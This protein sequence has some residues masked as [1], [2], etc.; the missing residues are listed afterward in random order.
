MAMLRR[1]S[2]PLISGA[3]LRAYTPLATPMKFHM[4]NSFF[5]G[6]RGPF[7]SGKS[8]S[9][10]MELLS[11]AME[12]KPYEGT[13]Y[14]RCACI[15]NSYP[16]L[17]STT[18]KTWTAWLPVSIC[19]V[20]ESIPITAYMNVALGDGTR[21]DFEAF[22]LS[23]DHPDDVRKLK[24]LE[25]TMLWMNEASE[26]GSEVLE[27]ASARVGRFPDKQIGGPSFSGIIADTNSPDDTHW[28]YKLAEVEKPKGYEFFTQPPAMIEVAPKESSGSV[29]VDSL[30]P[31]YVLNDGTKGLPPAENT[32]NLPEEYYEKMVQG[33][34]K[35][36]V[37]VYVLNNYGTI[38]A[39]KTVYPEYNDQLHYAGVEIPPNPGL[40]LLLGWDFGLNATAVA[41]QL[42]PKGQ[43]R[44]IDEFIGVDMGIQ[45][46][47]RE[48]VKP[49]MTA[50][51][52]RYRVFCVADPAGGQR[53]QTTEDTCFQILEEEGFPC[54]AAPTNEFVARRE[55]VSWYLTHL[56]SEGPAFRLSSKCPTL[57]QGFLRDYRY[58][59]MRGT[60]DEVWAPRPEK[61]DAS[62]SADALQYI[63]LYL[64]AGGY[65]FEESR[66]F[67]PGY[68]PE[69]RPVTV[70]H[71][72]VWD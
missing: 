64:R 31:Q 59:K 24:S 37:N 57:R 16:E 30:R 32:E 45:R 14:F 61:N 60:I 20:R 53:S 63:C 56:T 39:G 47:V 6:I 68:Q 34:S 29:L 1:K 50:C 72:A 27:A 70:S 10:V 2:Q 22:F 21:L 65:S 48:I 58:K 11:R 41:A 33:K 44:V 38:R 12:Q 17:L 23:L 25:L 40:I 55:A 43:L 62:H 69:V 15:R 35:E 8:V 46:F 13:R 3:Q 26:L 54:E 52:T 4:S 18:L 7:G 67:S 66:V 36:W 71:Q 49:K 9:C 5:R 42:S 51:Y 28:W 19:P